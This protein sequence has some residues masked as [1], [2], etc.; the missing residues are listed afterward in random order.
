[1]LCSCAIVLDPKIN[2]D[3]LAITKA[4]ATLMGQAF[5]ANCSPQV[6]LLAVDLYIDFVDI[7]GITL[8]TMAQTGSE[9]EPYGTGN[10]IWRETVAFICVHP[11]FIAI[12]AG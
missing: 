5:L 3:C 7:I 10:N 2:F 6:L 8:T 11:A 1:M 4:L 9:V 12:P